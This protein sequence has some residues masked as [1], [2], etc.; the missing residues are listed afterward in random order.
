MP[1]PE[2]R[3]A[4]APGLLETPEGPMAERNR[5]KTYLI[6]IVIMLVVLIIPYL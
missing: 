2:G 4:W 5:K 1:V 3:E 6:L